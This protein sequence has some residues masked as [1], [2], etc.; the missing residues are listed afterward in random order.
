ML[1][2]H[3]CKKHATFPTPNPPLADLAL[4]ADALDAAET[5]ASEGG[6][7]RTRLRDAALSKATDDMNLQVLYVQTVTLGDRDMTALAGMETQAVPS[8][9]PVPDMPEGFKVRPGTLE[10]SIYMFC[11]NTRYKREYVFEMWVEDTAGGGN[12]KGIQVQTSGRYQHEGLERGKIYRFRVYAKNSK[13][14]GLA[15]SEASCA[16]R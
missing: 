10:G 6:K 11:K 1:V 8:E 4:H 7:D 9:W 16:A 2:G 13:G 5:A 14:R 15:S 3:V 12:W